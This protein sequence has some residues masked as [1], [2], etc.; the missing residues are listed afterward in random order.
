RAFLEREEVPHTVL[1]P[2]E[3]VPTIARLLADNNVIG[4]FQGRMEFG[5]RALG[6][7]SILANPIEPTM[8][9]TLN[10][11]IKH[12]ELFRPFAPSTPLESVDDFFELDTR[13]AP[14][15]SPFMLFIARVRPEKRH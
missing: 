14:R 7:R 4:W 12:R 5:P 8:Q 2:A 15:E 1:H 9:D 6:A 11:K 13:G 3:L 10:A